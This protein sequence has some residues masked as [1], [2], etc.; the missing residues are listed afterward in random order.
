MLGELTIFKTAV[1]ILTILKPKLLG[2]PFGK[3]LKA[4][5]TLPQ[6]INVDG[7]C[8]AINKVKVTT[9]FKR[10][11]MMMGLNNAG[12]PPPRPPS[13]GASKMLNKKDENKHG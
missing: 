7:L 8:Q 6:T 3:I 9:A 1:A 4:L 11:F 13:S 10:R 5:A 2:E 12:V